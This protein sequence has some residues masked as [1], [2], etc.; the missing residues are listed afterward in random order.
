MPLSGGMRVKSLS[1]GFQHSRND[2]HAACMDVDVCMS[3]A[4][5]AGGVRKKCRNARGA[6]VI[7][8]RGL[9]GLAVHQTQIDHGPMSLCANV[10]PG[11][12]PSL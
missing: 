11:Q 8:A 10:G 12:L 4:D 5:K 3:F 7:Y 2:R 6:W 1:L 9:S